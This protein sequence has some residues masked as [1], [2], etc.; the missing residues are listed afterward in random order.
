M[1]SGLL[2]ILLIFIAVAVAMYL[3]S[4]EKKHDAEN[5]FINNSENQLVSSVFDNWKTQAISNRSEL[6]GC[7][8]RDDY[9]FDILHADYIDDES[10]SI[11]YFYTKMLHDTLHNIRLILK[12]FDDGNFPTE[13]TNLIVNN[14]NDLAKERSGLIKYKKYGQVDDSEWDNEKDEFIYNI[15]GVNDGYIATLTNKIIMAEQGVH[16]KMPISDY[17]QPDYEGVINK[18]FDSAIAQRAREL[19]KTLWLQSADVS[20]LVSSIVNIKVVASVSMLIDDILDEESIDTENNLVDKDL[21]VSNISPYDYEEMCAN[22]LNETGWIAKAT[23]KSGDQGADVYAEKDGLSVVLQCKLTN[24][25]VGNKAVQE[26]ISG[27]KYM[28]ADFSVVVTP[29]KYT[30][31]AQDIARVARVL[32]LHHEDLPHLESLCKRLLS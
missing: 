5:E 22:I 15:I 20:G 27:Q 11:F 18:F 16:D 26:A 6:I 19:Y 31:G 25:P 2:V 4:R 29:A 12:N 30:P 24:T 14:K 17:K 32:L 3:L 7:A 1:N 28:S 9:N 10:I 13:W 21:N 8:L 23:K